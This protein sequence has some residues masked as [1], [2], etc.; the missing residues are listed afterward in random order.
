MSSPTNTNNGLNQINQG[1][2]LSF[3]SWKKCNDDL[4][5]LQADLKT[6][7]NNTPQHILILSQIHHLKLMKKNSMDS[8][9]APTQF[10]VGAPHHTPLPAYL[11]MVNPSTHEDSGGTVLVEY[12][13]V[14]ALAPPNCKNP[15]QSSVETSKL[16]PTFDHT[17][18]QSDPS[19]PN[20][21]NIV[22]HSLDVDNKLILDQLEHYVK[23]LSSNWK[24]KIMFPCYVVN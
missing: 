4:R 12:A 11:H 14:P 19:I 15:V 6:I 22:T 5:Q 3:Q 1:E 7:P 20:Q 10:L 24:G 2:R 13:K 17:F 8:I 9:E 23:E 18:H 16:L 21:G